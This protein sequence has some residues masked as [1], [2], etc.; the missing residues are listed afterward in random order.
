MVRDIITDRGIAGIIMQDQLLTDLG[1]IIIVEFA[2]PFAGEESLDLLT[3]MN[4]LCAV[5]PYAV[6]GISLRDPLRIA[7]V[8]GIFGEP[9][10]L[11][12]GLSGKRRMWGTGQ[13][14]DILHLAY[15]E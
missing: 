13:F 6:D 8:P 3:A 11:R 14:T 7:A 9:C 12:G 1:Y 10:L 5:P 4:E 2:R 15:P